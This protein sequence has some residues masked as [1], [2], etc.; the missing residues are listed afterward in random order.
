MVNSG[1]EATMSCIR[2]ARGYTKKNKIIKFI[3]CY[4]GHVASLLV[5]AG[6]GLATLGIPDSPGIPEELSKLTIT[7]PYNDKEALIAAFKKYG[8]DVAA[9][10]IEPIAGNMG[11][12]EP[13]I[14]FLKKINKLSRE[15]GSLVIYDEVMTGFRVARG[16]AQELYKFKP[17][18]T[19]LGKIV[20]GGLPVGVYGGRSEIMDKI[21]PDGPIYQAGTLSGNPIAVS[22]GTALLKQLKDKSIYKDLE[23]NGKLFLEL[24]AEV[25]D[26]NNIPF[27]Y[28]I[29]GGMFGFF[30][31]K[32]LPK[33]FEEVNNSD[34]DLFSR[35]FQGMLQEKIYLPPSAFESCFL[36]TKHSKEILMKAAKSADKVFKSI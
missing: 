14:T 31:S 18:L 26:K 3:G 2:L 20:G 15:Y 11:F 21:A 4:H 32:D 16:G 12:I 8:K 30:F 33:N 6:S 36:S 9:L 17:D 24:L 35:F 19:A 28:N 29:R 13:E 23:K 1:P 27:S 5:K 7:I 10:I 25:A 34:L 22:A